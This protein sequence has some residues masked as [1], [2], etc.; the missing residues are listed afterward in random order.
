MSRRL[1]AAGFAGPL[2]GK[3]N[4]T[5]MAKSGS[6]K[7]AVAPRRTRRLKTSRGMSSLKLSGLL[8]TARRFGKPAV[9]VISLLVAVVAY[10]KLTSSKVFDLHRVE[11]TGADSGLEPDIERTVKQVVGKSKLLDVDLLGVRQKLEA[12]PRVKS[13]IVMRSLPDVLRVE[14]VAR[15]PA[16]PVLRQSGMIVWLDSDGVEVGDTA[17]VKIPGVEGIPPLASGFSEGT[18][19]PA[20]IAEDKERITAYKQVQK[21]LDATWNQ[22]DQVDLSFVND[23]RIRLIKPSIWIHLG[24]HDFGNRTETALKVLQA[25]KGGD[26]PM[27]RR[28]RVPE[29]DRF[30]QDMNLIGSIDVARPDRVVLSP[31][32]GAAATPNQPVTPKQQ[33]SKATKS[34]GKSK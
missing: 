10:N 28:Y 5:T 9:W 1:A 11:V 4:K 3:E 29:A 30:I 2:A 16:V 25:I 21:E 14:V 22:V 33:E 26:A 23:V 32:A 19:T 15:Q 6:R 27:L 34:P 31:V 17:T 24:S 8:E 7:Q 12:I 20:A 18:R 13:A